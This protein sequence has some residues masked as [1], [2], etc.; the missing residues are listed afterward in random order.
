[1]RLRKF[2]AVA[3]AAFWIWAVARPVMACSVCGGDPAAPM[4]QGMTMGILTLVVIIGMLLSGFV[5][6]FM[7][8]RIRAK[9]YSHMTVLDAHNTSEEEVIV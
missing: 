8:L 3:V 5:A 1:M 9:E 6:F 7:F 4:S 2:C